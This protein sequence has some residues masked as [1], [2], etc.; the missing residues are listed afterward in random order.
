MLKTEFFWT[1]QQ[2]ADERL[3][4]SYILHNDSVVHIQ[5]IQSNR[6]NPRAVVLRYPGNTAEHI[7]LSDPGFNRFRKPLPV[8]WVNHLGTKK[9]V[10]VERRPTRSRTHGFNENNTMV[11]SF[12]GRS[13]S[14]DASRD[15][16]I[17]EVCRDPMYAAAIKGEFPPIDTVLTKILKLTA[18]A[19][20]PDLCIQRDNDGLRWLYLNTDRVGL[21]VDN[22]TL[23]LMSAYS[24]AKEQIAENPAFKISNIKEF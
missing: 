9:A 21:F 10:F 6:G 19:V 24:Y 14:L 4:G 7:L 16:R 2:Q 11:R 18:I 12:M 13:M 15:L 5:E 23:L 3:R 8:G 22:D 1:D 17:S 20:A